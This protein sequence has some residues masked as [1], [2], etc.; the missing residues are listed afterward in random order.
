MPEIRLSRV[1]SVSSE[2]PRFP[3]TN[4]LSPDSGARWQS[5]KAGEK[6]ISVVLELPG[7]KPIHSLHIGNYGSA[8]VEVLVGAGA[9]GDFQVLLPTAAFLSPNESRAG[10]EL[11]R[12]RLFGP[13]ALVQ[14]GAGKSWDRLRLV[15]SQPY[16]Q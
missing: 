15:C 12:L 3:A 8:F 5:A 9:G 16:C 14:A 11:R 10:A 2:D 4:L 1:V 13:Q 6:Q 7:D